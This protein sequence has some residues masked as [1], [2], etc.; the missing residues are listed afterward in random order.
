MI[1]LLILINLFAA[2]LIGCNDRK[3]SSQTPPQGGSQAGPQ[4]DVSG[5]GQVN[6]ENHEGEGD[7]SPP[8]RSG[9]EIVDRVKQ[10]RQGTD[11]SLYPPSVD[12]DQDN[13]PNQPVPGVDRV[14][15]CPDVFNPTQDD[16]DGDG[17]GDAC[18]TD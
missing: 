9:G 3:E 14:D 12:P 18:D 8:P 5:D 16:S 2:L 17:H 15:N 10:L 4:V 6:H 11:L 13:V 7:E 1:N